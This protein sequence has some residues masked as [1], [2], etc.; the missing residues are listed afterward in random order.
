M[1]Y[2]TRESEWVRAA[3]AYDNG[4]NAGY[5]EGWEACE[6]ALG[7]AADNRWRNGF[8]TGVL[9]ALTGFA[10]ATL[11]HIGGIGA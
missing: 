11:T 3:I 2:R 1:S 10:L 7:R 5:R 6:R 4:H 8:L 9:S